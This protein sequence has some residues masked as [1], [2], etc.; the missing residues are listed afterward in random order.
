VTGHITWIGGDTADNAPGVTFKTGWDGSKKTGGI[1][2]DAT[3]TSIT[4]PGAPPTILNDLAVR[5]SRISD[6]SFAG[7]VVKQYSG[8]AAG[9]T[10]TGW[11][12]RTSASDPK[13]RPHT[14]T[15]G[16]PAIDTGTTVS[17]NG[18]VDYAGSRLC[19]GAPDIGALGTAPRSPGDTMPAPGAVVVQGAIGAPGTRLPAGK[20][21][22]TI[23]RGRIAVV[24]SKG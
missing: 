17:G 14:F 20:R 24:R 16:S 1:V 3:V 9:A 18:G 23:D 21:L 7:I 10:A 6:T 8:D 13:F 4:A 2:F 22:P 19:N 5:N 12:S 11:G 15:A